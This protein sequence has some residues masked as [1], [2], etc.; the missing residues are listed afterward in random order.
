[1]KQE[2]LARRVFKEKGVK[3]EQQVLRVQQA[4]LVQP[5]RKESVA[6]QAH[7]GLKAKGVKP[8]L[9][10]RQAPKEFKVFKASKVYRV[11]L[12]SLA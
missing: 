4:L 5:E 6:R 7:K 9:Q 10:E 8:E 12:A 1:V 2:P 11:N 3:P